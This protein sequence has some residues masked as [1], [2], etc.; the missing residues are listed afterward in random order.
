VLVRPEVVDPQLRGPRFTA[1]R[2]LVE[3]EDVRLDS[4]GIEDACGETEQG[5]DIAALEE[6]PPYGLPSSTL[7]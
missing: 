6:L 7:A 3:E 2:L 4:L 5:M 1:S